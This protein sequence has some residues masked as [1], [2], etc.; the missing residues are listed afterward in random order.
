MQ[1]HLYEGDRP[2]GPQMF[3]GWG[4]TRS[5]GPFDPGTTF[6]SY[7]GPA[8]DYVIGTDAKKAMTWPV[9]RAAVSKPTYEVAR[10]DDPPPEAAP[11]LT[12][13]TY[14]EPA[15]PPHDYPSL[16][17]PHAVSATDHGVDSSDDDAPAT[18]G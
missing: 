17:G 13:A 3:A 2:A 6:A 1:P 4:G 9:E 7:Q 16:G 5:T 14:E 15:P 10:N 11:V 12:R 8:P 18:S